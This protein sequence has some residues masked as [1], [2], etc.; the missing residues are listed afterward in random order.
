MYTRV[1]VDDCYRL[2]SKQPQPIVAIFQSIKQKQQVMKNKKYLKDL[3]T[4]DGRRV[5]IND[6]I[7]PSSTRPAAKGQT[8]WTAEA[9]ELHGEDKV[10]F[11]RAGL[12]IAGSALQEEGSLPP[13]LRS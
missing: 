6:N 5:Y 10:G 7:P 9:V 4:P 12:T 3:A 13:L 2:G 8:K 11:T 1:E